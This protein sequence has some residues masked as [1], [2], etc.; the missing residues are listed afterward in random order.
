MLAMGAPDGIEKRPLV[1]GTLVAGMSAASLMRNVPSGEM[2]ANANWPVP[3]G[4]A[5]SALPLVSA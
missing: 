2:P 3:P 1:P 4:I 5:V